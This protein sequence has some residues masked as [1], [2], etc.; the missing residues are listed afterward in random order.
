MDLN[1]L[2]INDNE[3]ANLRT[4]AGTLFERCLTEGRPDALIGFIEHQVSG[5][6][7]RADVLS[8]LAED[9]HLRLL[10]LRELRFDVRE[11][12]LN[13]IRSDYGVDMSILAPPNALAD[14]H[15]VE[16]DAVL[17]LIRHQHP[18]DTCEVKV[19][20]EKVEKSLF[21][22]R[23]LDADIRLTEQ[24]FQCALDW[25]DGLTV[26]EARQCRRL[27]WESPPLYPLQ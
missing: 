11:R 26:V 7:P 4:E 5:D 21:Q 24:L 10:G 19:V 1:D 6:P 15:R 23:Q 2:F 17:N 14:Y 8:W 20:R 27:L 3:I 25:A 9:L 12:A 22:A 18:L 13:T 16:P